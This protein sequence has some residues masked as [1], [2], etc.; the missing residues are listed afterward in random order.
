MRETRT[1]AFNTMDKDEWVVLK[2]PQANR[3]HVLCDFCDG[4]KIDDK[5]WLEG[6]FSQNLTVRE[7]LEYQRGSD[8]VR[9]RACTDNLLRK[10]HWRGPRHKVVEKPTTRSAG[11]SMTSATSAKKGKDDMSPKTKR[12]AGVM[13]ESEMKMARADFRNRVDRYN[14]V[15]LLESER[16]RKRDEPAR[17]IPKAPF[18]RQGAQE[19]SSQSSVAP[20]ATAWPV[21]QSAGEKKRRKPMG[22]PS[23][24]QR[25]GIRS[26]I[27]AQPNLRGKEKTVEFEGP[28]FKIKDRV[29]YNNPY[30][31]GCTGEGVITA[32]IQPGIEGYSLD[33]G[34]Y[35]Y[36][37]DTIYAENQSNSGWVWEGH[38]KLDKRSSSM[39]ISTTSYGA[40]AL[41]PLD[42]I[43]I[44]T[45]SAMPVSTE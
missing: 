37:I 8:R 17:T 19:H 36:E 25:L 9:R 38:V 11:S 40:G 7:L 21:L 39:P 28:I 4:D 42:Y 6:P 23:R 18:Q 13:C 35:R 24:S 20:I 14:H 1:Q 31:Q 43:G 41:H 12:R 45:C 3:S 33:D 44:D 22:K 27:D 26:L 34:E 15:D 5:H 2:V 29:V 30:R 10:A 16:K 32:V